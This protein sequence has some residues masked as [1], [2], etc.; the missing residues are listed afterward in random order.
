[1]LTFTLYYCIYLT[2]DPDFFSIFPSHIGG[3]IYLHVDWK[4]ATGRSVQFWFIVHSKKSGNRDL[5]MWY[6][7][8]EYTLYSLVAYGQARDAAILLALFIVG[9]VRSCSLHYLIYIYALMVLAGLALRRPRPWRS[10]V[11]KGNLEIGVR[12]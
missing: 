1:M 12:S 3:H 9:I 10:S 8:L 11:I 6:A 2:F 7:N 4:L 5:R